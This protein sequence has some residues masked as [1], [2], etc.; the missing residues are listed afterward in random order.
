M[1]VVNKAAVDGKRRWDGEEG[2]GR[3]RGRR[4]GGGVWRGLAGGK[5]LGKLNDDICEMLS[6]LLS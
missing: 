3:G 2:G 1:L 5:K 4:D 6:R